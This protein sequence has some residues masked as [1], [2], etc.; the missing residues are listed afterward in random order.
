MLLIYDFDIFR[1]LDS[2][3]LLENPA[4]Y[5]VG[6]GSYSLSS[7]GRTRLGC[8][9]TQSMETKHRQFMLP[10][11]TGRRHRPGWSLGQFIHQMAGYI[12][13]HLCLFL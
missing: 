1:L 7:D 6:I 8:V 11:I 4:L 3:P 2:L 5:R 13:G 10:A 9:C 12:Y